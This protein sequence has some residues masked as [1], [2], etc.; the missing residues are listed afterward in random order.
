[1]N[2][3]LTSEVQ[4]QFDIEKKKDEDRILKIKIITVYPTLPFFIIH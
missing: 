1:M 2:K 4:Q 3:L